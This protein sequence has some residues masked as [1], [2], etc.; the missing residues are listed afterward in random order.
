MNSILVL[1]IAAVAL[2]VGYGLYARRIDRDVVQPDGKKATPAKMYMDGVDFTPASRNVLFG[3]QFKSIAALGPITGPIIAVQWGWFPAMLWIILGTFFIGWVQDYGAMMMGVRRDGDS[4]GALSYKLVSPRARTILMIFLYFYLLLIMGSFGNAVGKTLMTNPKVPLGMFTVVLMGILAGQ[5]T[6]KWKKDIILTTVVTVVLTFV[7]IWVST[8]K[9]VADFFTGLYGLPESPQ[10]FLGNTRAQVIGTLLV[11]AFCYLGS[12]M[13]IWSFAQ[14]INYISFWIVS[15]GVLGGILG[16]IIWRPGMGDFP[17]FTKFTTAS[18]PLWPMLFVT[19][20]CGAISGWHSLVSTSGTARQLEAET[21]A[22]PV[23]G[24]AMFLEMIFA[25]VAFL[26]ATAAFGGFQ[27]YQDAGGAGKALA[28]FSGGLA[29][30][31]SHI[32]IPKEFGTAYGSVFL[33]IMA[34][35]IMQLVVRFMRVA[36]AELVGEKVPVMKNIHVGTIV[37]LI[38]TLV[39]VWVIPWLT[40][41]SAFGA[42]NQLMAGL[43]LMLIALWAMSEGRKH[44]WA[45]YPAVFMIV[46]TIAALLYLAYTNFAKLATPNITTQAAIAAVLVGIIA[47]VLVVAAVFLVYDGWKALRKPH[48]KKAPAKA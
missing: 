9:P 12:V 43:A 38:L 15:L 40:I 27:G 8:L 33:T 23:G 35:T 11:I 34:L 30:F 26:T 42:A 1:L 41:W 14:P 13:P 31:L 48:G 21:D 32:G 10:W 5:M 19:I 29:N 2:V 45:L 22:L 16:M 46:T 24:G 17:A 39:F 3:Y 37:A 4:L 6:Y 18:G 28:V 20:A 7:G 36:S 44:S 47:V 25:T